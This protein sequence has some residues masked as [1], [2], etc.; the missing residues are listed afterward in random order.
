MICPYALTLILG[1]KILRGSEESRHLAGVK[2]SQEGPA[3]A[4]E[5]T[6]G[7]Q[8]AGQ[9]SKAREAG[10]E[11]RGRASPASVKILAFPFPLGEARSHGG[12]QAEEGHD[13]T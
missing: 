11:G 2:N 7:E 6:A 13:L 10:Q 3:V 1:G 12:F 9:S 5:R 4:A 8:E